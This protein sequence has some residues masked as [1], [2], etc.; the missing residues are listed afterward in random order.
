[1]R[2][3]RGHAGRKPDVVFSGDCWLWAKSTVKGYGQVKV[4]GKMRLAHRYFYERFTGA[5]PPG[6]HVHHTCDNTKCVRPEHLQVLSPR[7]HRRL[8]AK[9]SMEAARDIRKR[10]AQGERLAALAR[11]YGV[12]PSAVW[13]LVHGKSWPE[14]NGTVSDHGVAG[15]MPTVRAARSEQGDAPVS[16]AT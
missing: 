3:R 9:L 6:H 16:E 2:Y 12:S 7:Q 13:S 10:V 15:P 5:I 8:S 11:E 1:V 4:D 14:D